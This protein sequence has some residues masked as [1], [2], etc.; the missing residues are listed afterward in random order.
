MAFARLVTSYYYESLFRAFL[1]NA[2]DVVQIDKRLIRWFYG[3]V[4][5]PHE[6]FGVVLTWKILHIHGPKGFPPQFE[7]AERPRG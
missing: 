4:I 2:G 7:N 6:L 3:M 5:M 1:Q